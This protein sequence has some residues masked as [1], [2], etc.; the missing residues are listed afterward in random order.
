MYVYNNA[1]Y[2]NDCKY[3]MFIDIDEFLVFKNITLHDFIRFKKYIHVNWQFYGDD[4]QIYKSN[5][6]VT[7][8][9]TT[10]LTIGD[11]EHIKSI[12]QTR[13]KVNFISPHFC[14]TDLDCKTPM[15]KPCDGRS[16][17][18]KPPELD[19]AILNH[20]VTKTAEEFIHKMQRSIDGIFK[21]VDFFFRV[22]KKTP[23]KINFF[24]SNNI[25]V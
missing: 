6:P 9:F 3:M 17:F 1:Y 22:N 12:V 11:N 2:N 4:D 21:N 19:C 13:N 20:Y 7:E 25:T 10:P 14:V 16:P 24:K 23:E 5:K 8:R 18:N 15:G